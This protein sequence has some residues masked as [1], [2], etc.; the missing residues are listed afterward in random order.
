M[1]CIPRI[2]HIWFL[3]SVFIANGLESIVEFANF[4]IACV[5]IL[6][7][8]FKFV[9]STLKHRTL[10]FQGLAL[11]KEL[12]IK[13]NLVTLNLQA[14]SQWL[15]LEDETHVSS[16]TKFPPITRDLSHLVVNEYKNFVITSSCKL[17]MVK[18]SPMKGMRISPGWFL[19]RIE[20]YTNQ[21][22][23]ISQTILVSTYLYTL[24]ICFG[25]FLHLR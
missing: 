8:S 3:F 12:Y 19:I 5:K 24:M 21:I 22:S 6:H 23:N 15:I 18:D 7:H 13:Q 20:I 25:G 1:L 16:S 14:M 4:I 17:W 2:V 9:C 11:E 10:K